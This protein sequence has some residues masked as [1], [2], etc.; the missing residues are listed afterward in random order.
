MMTFRY[1]SFLL[2]ILIGLVSCKNS[3]NNEIE[4][5]LPS[6]FINMA[7]TAK[8]SYLQSR[9]SPDSLAHVISGAILGEYEKIVIDSLQDVVVQLNC[10]YRESDRKM[11][12]AEFDSIV[13]ALPAR[14]RAKIYLCSG[15]DNI[16]RLSMQIMSEYM[17]KI[18][19]GEIDEAVF[20]K[21]MDEY[22]EVFAADSVAFR[23]FCI[24]MQAASVNYKDEISESI[25]KYCNK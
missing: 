17:Q 1:L 22:K 23:K 9:I 10:T 25:I 14:S 12:S 20:I 24:G 8:V 13:E 5:E 4:S 16:D 15:L 11:F 7:D 3:G 2:L 19:S 21:T 6:D 18:I